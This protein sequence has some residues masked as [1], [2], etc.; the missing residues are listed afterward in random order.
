MIVIFEVEFEYYYFENR[1]LDD[2]GAA[3][4]HED[5]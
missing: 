4:V 1:D 2:E 5:G 3:G